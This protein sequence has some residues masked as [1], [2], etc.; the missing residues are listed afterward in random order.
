MSTAITIRDGIT[1]GLVYLA[2]NFPKEYR[3]ALM[4]V[5]SRYAKMMR[6]EI[7]AGAPAGRA[8]VPLNPI[9]IFL[10]H[11]RL[12]AAADR[13]TV[14]Y[15][16]AA[17]LNRKR[18]ARLMRTARDMAVVNPTKHFSEIESNMQGFGGK[19]PDL[20]R[21][22]LLG[23]NTGV[24]VGF[25]DEKIP[26]SGKAFARY[27][28]SL[29][30]RPL[31]NREKHRMHIL[32]GKEMPMPTSYTKPERLGVSPYQAGMAQD[33][34]RSITKSVRALLQNAARKGRR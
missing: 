10:R 23:E 4:D 31:S 26:G 30:P 13:H 25:L 12:S 19:L 32:L 21:F 5:G 16:K 33:A 22:D 11:R 34:E 8:F 27:Q 14:R 1:P 6:P 24:A 20:T 7:R 9:T 15:G 17:N 2:E 3:K 28:R 18:A 29:G